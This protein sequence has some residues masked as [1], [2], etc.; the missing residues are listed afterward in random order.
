MKR[1][2]FAVSM[3][4]A[5]ALSPATKAAPLAVVEFVSSTTNQSAFIPQP[6]DASTFAFMAGQSMNAGTVTAFTTAQGQL[7]ITYR[8]TGVWTIRETH[9][10]V[11]LQPSDF[12]QT[13]AGNPQPGQFDYGGPQPTGTTAVQ[14]VFNWGAAVPPGMVAYI[15]AHAVV[16]GQG[17]QTAWS[18]G[19][20]FPGKNWFTYSKY[21]RPAP[22]GRQL[23]LT[24]SFLPGIQWMDYDG[25]FEIQVT[26][27]GLD[28]APNVV[29]AD[30]LDAR[31]LDP[32]AFVT[33]GAGTCSVV[34]GSLS[35]AIPTL[36]AGG[37]VVIRAGYHLAYSDEGPGSILNCATAT[38]GDGNTARG[39]AT[40]SYIYGPG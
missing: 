39:C 15:G 10:E 34:S 25:E 23:V 14:Y 18:A 5:F 13:K 37:T 22:A 9:L 26:N 31:F 11:V 38:D 2:A 8:A 32:R 30:I 3:C 1:I 35:C 27:N 7:V 33:S 17:N 6:S 24:K 16:N 4:V 29:I 36:P 40:L 12:P 28:A 19:F 21:V 20:P